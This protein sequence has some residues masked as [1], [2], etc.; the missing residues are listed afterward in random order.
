MGGFARLEF[1]QIH[2]FFVIYNYGGGMGGY[3]GWGF[4]RIHKFTNYSFIITTMGNGRICQMKIGKTWK[5][6]EKYRATFFVFHEFSNFSLFITM[7]ENG[8]ICQIGIHT[9]SRIFRDLT[10]VG[11]W[12]DMPDGDSHE[13]TNS[14]IIH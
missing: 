13:F 10:T 8:W 2:E 6:T 1:T 12:E 7:M 14:R 4:T 11:E 9:N 3:A 5:K